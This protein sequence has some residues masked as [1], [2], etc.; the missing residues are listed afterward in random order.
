MTSKDILLSLKNFF[1]SLS[2][3]R[4]V[5]FILLIG[6][7]AAGFI[8]LILWSGRPDFRPLYS[9]LAAEDAG[10]VIEKLKSDKIPYRVTAG[11]T[12][13]VP[14]DQVFE[15]TMMLASQGLPQGGGVGFEIFDR[16][17]LGMT[18][19]ELDVR[20]QRALQ[21][22][23]ARTI[24]R[25][26][27]VRSCRVHI[28]MPTKSLF[29]EEEKPASASVTLTLEPARRLEKNQ[30]RGITH[31]LS[32]SVPDLNPDHISILD[33]M[34]NLLTQ[35][36]SGSEGRAMESDFLILQQ[37]I[38]QDLELRVMSM[39]MPVLGPDKAIVRIS[40]DLDLKRQE[41]TEERFD[42]DRV[43]RSEQVTETTSK[44]AGPRPAG[45][46]GVLSNVAEIGETSA[47]GKEDSTYTRRE[48]TTNYE[49]SKLVRRVVNPVGEVR[50]ISVAVIVDG[51]YETV[52][53]AKGKEP[54]MK[55]RPRSPEE[56]ETIKKIVQR[57]VN[58]DPD[59]GDQ[60][61]VATIPFKASRV[62]TDAPPESGWERTVN[63]AMPLLKYL[64]AGL[65]LLFLFL[66]VLRP[67]VKWMTSSPPIDGALLKKLPMTIG[68]MEKAY[69]DTNALPLGNQLS[70]AAMRDK[71]RTV[72]VI[73][74]WLQ[75]K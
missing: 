38:Q 17:K 20:Y 22:E 54:S 68:E 18:E 39:L 42:P 41:T 30:L 15:V 74:N 3:A 34:G 6:S 35:V 48:K 13:L 62:N 37:K 26:S 73:R 44:G 47:A 67:L 16:T 1:G 45:V 28:V 50:K 75:E 32:H 9:N 12:I 58:Y 27:E 10:A 24:S 5:S 14:G 60:I 69:G 71:D 49:I 59:R 64:L 65:L 43:P 23:L 57:A 63:L 11:N 56:L 46:P 2:L 66:G 40:C 51:T 7:T 29:V 4:K 52:P 55:Y 72:Q 53:G 36:G 70:R 25:L 61:E 8:V 21:G 31:L 19:F 33:N